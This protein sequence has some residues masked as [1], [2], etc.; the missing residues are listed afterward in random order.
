VNRKTVF[1]SFASIFLVLATGL[2]I[3]PVQAVETQEYRASFYCA[4][5]GE[6]LVVTKWTEQGYMSEWFIGRGTVAFAGSGKVDQNPP[7]PPML[8]YTSYYRSSG[9]LARGGVFACWGKQMISVLLYSNGEAGGLFVD[10]GMMT[11]VFLAG[12]G[13]GAGLVL[14]K[15][16]YRDSSGMHAVNGK[17][18]VS[19]LL[20]PGSTSIMIMQV[21]LIKPDNTILLSMLLINADCSAIG[22]A[23]A[24]NYFAHSVR[25]TALS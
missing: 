16:I 21:S 17:A 12:P 25:I 13:P 11:D 1:F 24:P 5:G 23:H 10:E 14:Y 8:P 9:I 2:I 4:A 3:A 7:S 22:W 19:V 20:A 18:T 15:G 6:C